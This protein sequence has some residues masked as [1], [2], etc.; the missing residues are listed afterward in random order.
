MRRG[1]ADVYQ[2]H[3]V[4]STAVR[5]MMPFGELFT[6]QREEEREAVRNLFSLN[7]EK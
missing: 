5:P 1:S 4:D 7:T 6:D 3:T 2:R